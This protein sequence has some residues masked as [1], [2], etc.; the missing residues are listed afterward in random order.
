MFIL[1]TEKK[2]IPHNLQGL[3]G[4]S[5]IP[6]TRGHAESCCYRSQNACNSLKNEFPSFLFH[7]FESLIV[8]NELLSP[9]RKTNKNKR[10]Q[11]KTFCIIVYCFYMFLLGLSCFFRRRKQIP[12]PPSSV[13]TPPGG[14]E[15]GGSLPLGGTG[16]AAVRLLQPTSPFLILTITACGCACCVAVRNEE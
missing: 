5:L 8:N 10:K 16:W 14:G 9:F 11:E 1:T 7:V 6:P 4:I 2:Y 15:G 3:R 13:S 12:P